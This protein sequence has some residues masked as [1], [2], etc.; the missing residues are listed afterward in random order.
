MKIVAEIEQLD[1]KVSVQAIKACLFYTN[2]H[3][4][5]CHTGT[6]PGINSSQYDGVLV[7]LGDACLLF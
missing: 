7:P 2:S 3:L 6:P 4:L 1:T 5:R